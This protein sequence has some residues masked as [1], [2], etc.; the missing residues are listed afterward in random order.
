M[1]TTVHPQ[2]T[3]VLPVSTGPLTG[4]L[5]IVR[6]AGARHR[7][8]VQDGAWTLPG[9]A[10]VA[11]TAAAVALIAV[12]VIAWRDAASPALIGIALAALAVAFTPDLLAALPEPADAE[13]ESR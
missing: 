10:L 8:A 13:T 1:T 12:A 4:S 6:A 7:T 5:Q 11:A 9:W 2:D 3:G